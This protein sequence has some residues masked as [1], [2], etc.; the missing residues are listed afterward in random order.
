M[1][2]PTSN[3]VSM[4]TDARQ[5]TLVYGLG[6]T[7]LSVARYLKRQRMSATFTD[8]RTSPP[9]LE[10]LGRVLPDAEVVLGELP[11]ERLDDFDT[12]IVSPGI[13]DHDDT[14]C[15]L[16]AAGIDIR[17]DIDLF[18]R[19][20]SADIVAVTGSNGKSTVTTLIALMCE[21]GGLRPLAGG[22]LG[23]A[24]LDLLD[25][26]T[27]DLYVLELSSFQLQRTRELPASVAV[28]LNISADH[29]DWHASEEEYRRAKLRIFNESRAMVFNRDET[30][31]ARPTRS[32]IPGVSFGLS[33]P[34][35]GQFG[36]LSENG[37]VYLARGS[38]RL[39]PVAEIA[40]LGRHNQANALAALAAC[41][42]IGL[43]LEPCLEVLRTFSGLPHRM[44]FVRELNG[45][46]YINDSKATNVAAAIASVSAVD[47]P[48]VLLAGGQGK[49]GDF[50]ELAAATADRLRAVIVYG[51]DAGALQA[52][53]AD[54]VPI[55]RAPGLAQALTAA[56][57]AATGLARETSGEPVTVLLAPACASFD[58]FDNYLRRGE[59]FCEHV[60]GWAA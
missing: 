57:E 34:D 14:L 35:D 60:N 38:D 52:A 3:A 9:G 58:Q 49:G 33:A 47:G 45:V 30:A 56:R 29:L 48:L 22:N 23:D 36:L 11:G 31:N 2:T 54:A 40:L 10:A 28:L 37:S 53:F 43:P 25:E 44:Q 19:E 50:E 32:D 39:L 41:E 7:G 17:S 59:A 55:V 5:A 42:L 26:V 6:T 24:A 20:A 51:E 46:R 21:A 16:R 15:R 18:V 8:S 1:T 13:P 27:P 4:A 12:A